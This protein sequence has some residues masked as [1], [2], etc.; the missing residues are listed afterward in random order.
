MK[1]LFCA[2]F[3]LLF[4][5]SLLVGCGDVDRNDWLG[6]GKDDDGKIDGGKYD[7][8][9]TV[10]TIPDVSLNL[11]IIVED[12]TLNSEGVVIP[13]NT[14]G[15]IGEITQATTTVNNAIK[16]FTSTNYHTSVNVIYIKAS[17][18]DKI[19]IDAVNA[20][21]G[22]AKA[23]NIVL[24]NSYSLMQDLYATGKLCPLDSYLDTT[25][26]G[27]LNTAIPTSLLEA[28]KMSTV[29][30]GVSSSALYTIPNNH[31]IGNYEYLLI[32]KAFVRDL[33]ISESEAL[34]LNS[35]ENAEE[36]IMNAIGASDDR[37]V[38]DVIALVSG[39]Y[40]DRF[41]YEQNGYYCNV[42]KSPIA[43]KNEAFLSA[44]AIVDRNSAASNVDINERAMEIVYNI[45]MNIELRNLLQYGVAGT[46]YKLGDDDGV[47]DELL[48][49][50][51]RYSMNLL[52]TGN[53][54]SA[55]I[56]DAVGWTEETKENAINQNADS[57]TVEQSKALGSKNSIQ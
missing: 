43:D 45:N 26:Y 55:Y 52:Y 18:Y 21:N 32:N 57:I 38:E 56:C 22:D 9:E 47:I 51:N 2:L 31:V 15:K 3:C 44:F 23:A 10:V 13:S 50:S 29:I 48:L 35:Y 41:A 28:S 42:V 53:V 30:D 40:E 6:D 12:E 33:K 54:M 4:T 27:R 17:D 36:R 16:D 1:K 7:G 11:Y 34:A 25:K 8:Y 24:V 20:V 5:A 39:S 37:N 14:A 49:G 46:N 19:A